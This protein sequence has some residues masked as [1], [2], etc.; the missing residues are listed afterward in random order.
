MKKILTLA[1]LIFS[2]SLSA[3]SPSFAQGM[4]NFNNTSR[5]N[6]DGHTAREEAEGKEIRDKLQAG[7]LKCD[8]LSDENFGALG[9]YFMG[10]MAG[11]SHEAMNNMMI[12]MMGEEGEE[13]MHVAMGKRMSDCE[14][15][16]AMPQNMINS[17]MMQM[18]IGG[19]MMGNWSNSSALNNNFT[20][21]MS[22]MNFGFAPFGWIFMILFWALVIAGIVALIK[23]I[24]GQNKSESEKDKTALAILKERYAKGEIG[25]KEFEEKK[26]DLN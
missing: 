6:D 19:G 15:N 3:P 20:N 11:D 9:E 8:D 7:E 14:P 24:A 4:M 16:A 23:W 10:Q 17:G 2:F 18:M 22:M 26:K 12:A 25:K 5:Q 13:E 1:I 21:P